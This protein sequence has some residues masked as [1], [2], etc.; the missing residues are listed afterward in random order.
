VEEPPRITSLSLAR[1]KSSLFDDLADLVEHVAV[2]VP[3]VVVHRVD[4][5]PV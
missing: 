3:G 5:R 1:R 4:A 2:S